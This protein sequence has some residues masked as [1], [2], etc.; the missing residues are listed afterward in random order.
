MPTNLSPAQRHA[1]D[2]LT[3]AL[4]AGSL[5]VLRGDTGTGRTTVL[6]ELHHAN[7][8]AFL[9]LKEFVDALRERDPLAMEE[10]IEELVLTALQ[11]HDTVFID[12]FHLLN[13]VICD[14][15]F[16]MYPRKGFLNLPL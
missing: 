10:T 15:G 6:R 14:C 9:T 1:Y 5:F 4:P 8:G 12:D 13:D 7:G 3:R 16:T 11:T 2:G